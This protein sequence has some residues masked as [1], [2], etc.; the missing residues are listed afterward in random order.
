VSVNNEGKLNEQ[1]IRE[2]VK[3]HSGNVQ[4]LFVNLNLLVQK[5]KETLNE[6]QLFV[7]WNN[8]PLSKQVHKDGRLLYHALV[9]IVEE[10][11]GV[12][13]IKGALD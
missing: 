7:V 10:G 6:E 5:H 11:L 3:E 8:S 1:I 4:N 2:Y 12:K 13:V 9:L